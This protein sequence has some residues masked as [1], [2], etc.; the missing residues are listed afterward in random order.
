MDN[1]KL[2][3]LLHF[4]QP[5]WQFP[6]V[7]QKI[8]EQC[9]RPIFHYVRNCGQGFAFTANINYS[10]LE[11]L[12]KYE[13]NDVLDD[14][15]YCVR[16]GLIELVGTAAYHPIIPLIPVKDAGLQISEDVIKKHCMGIKANSKGFFFPEMAFSKNS[17]HL[18]HK[19]GFNWTVVEDVA[20]LPE[21]VPFDYI[22]SHQGYSVF[23]RS[24]HW[25]KYI[26]NDHVS[27]WE[28]RERLKCELPGWTNGGSGYIVIAM[29]A[30]TFGHHV[31]GLSESFLF[32]LIENWGN[33]RVVCPF[34][35]MLTIFPHRENG[36]LRDCSWSTS[37]DDLYRN[38]PFPLWK[39]RDNSA[40]LVLW[41]LVEM[42][43]KYSKQVNAIHQ[44][45]KI[46]NSCHWWWISRGFWNPQFMLIGARKA[47]EIVE[48]CGTREEK[49]K[50]R[51]HLDV[52]ESLG[53]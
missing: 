46:V 20:V 52:L 32:P 44:C 31:P 16:N 14:I 8:V 15:K 50:A 24:S 1:F 10:L 28:F 33:R 47:F 27:F 48:K 9:Y 21:H 43:L 11:L 45:F 42:A 25:S 4:F 3:V 40:Q 29:D 34:E 18:L 5:Y 51:W 7:L 41:D 38:D 13:H 53:R 26:W 2:G 12:V 30:E 19:L 36:E 39:S 17:F 35:D 22:I 23:L 49:K 6:H 37:Y